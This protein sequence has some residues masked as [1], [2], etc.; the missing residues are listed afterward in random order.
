MLQWY[1]NEQ[2][3]EEAT[4]GEIISKLRLV[5]ED[6]YGLLMID[7]ELGARTAPAQIA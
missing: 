5:K 1:V 3:E 2:V 4:V 7:N 6:G